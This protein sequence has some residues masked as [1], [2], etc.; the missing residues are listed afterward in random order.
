MATIKRK[1]VTCR[2]EAYSFPHRQDSKEC[3]ALYNSSHEA[4]Y[5]PDSIKSLGLTSLFAPDNRQPVR[6]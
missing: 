4:G 3:K 1:Q 6:F 5:E 2:C